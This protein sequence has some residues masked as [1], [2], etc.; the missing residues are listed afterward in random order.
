MKKNTRLL[1]LLTIW[2][3]FISCSTMASGLGRNDE[4]LPAASPTVTYVLSMPEPQTHYFEVEMQ[5]RNVATVTNS[6]KNGYIDIKMPVWTPGS[7]LI[8]E[9]AKNVEG[10]TAS[11]GGKAVVSDKVSKNTWRVYTGDDNLT[12]RYR[13]YANDLTVR[14]CFVDAE[15]GYVTPAGM[16]MYHDALKDIPLRLVVQPYKTWKKVATGLPPVA[17]QEFTYEAPNLDILI[18]SPLEI[19]NH[20]TF[21]FTAAGVPHTVA[22]V[23]DVEYDEER[24]KA[25]Y[26][27]ICETAFSVV[28][29][30]PCK[31]YTFIVQHILQGGGGLEHL[32]STTL[33]PSRNAYTTEANYKRFF[34]LVAHEYFHLWNVKRIRPIALG[35]FDYENENY[36]HMLWLSEG[37][38]SFYGEYIQMR[39]G[40]YS[41]TDYLGL[42]ANDITSIENQP[43]VRVQSV[44]ESSWDAWIK[45]YRPNENSLNSTISY[46]SKGSVLGLLLNLAIL[47]GSNGARNMDDLMR[48][49]YTEYYKKQKRGFTDAEFRQAAEQIAGRKL[50]DFFTIGVN[51]AE[52][53]NYNTYV[54]LVGMQLVNVAARTQD[55]FLGTAT[56]YSNGKATVT[57]VRRGSAAYTG[58]LNVGDEIISVD[59]VRVTDDLLKLISGRRVGETINVLVNRAGFLRKIPVT[60]TQNPLVSYRLEPLPNQTPAQKA[61]YNKWLF[62]K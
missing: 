50:D 10:F 56:V 31:D 18:D 11:A 59:S 46:Y 62:I 24:L 43:G 7:Y 26:K 19:G 30:H 29:E 21:T 22:M 8:R 49:L 2:T 42:V 4:N 28:G 38:T 35:P 5:L 37:C 15:H 58:G 48:F 25:D 55:G 40:F 39:A 61:L 20:K 33:E 53:I 9:Y 14:T 23:G 54:E 34:G 27:R 16:F 32:N 60:L 36:T 12:I 52:P 45:G 17:G 13:V 51:S 6:K 44:A 41:P 47:A 3:F 57:G 1:Y